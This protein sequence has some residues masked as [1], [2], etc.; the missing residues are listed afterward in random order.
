MQGL[1]ILGGVGTVGRLLG[2]GAHTLQHAGHF[3]HGPFCG[4]RQ[5]DAVVGV[6]VALIQAVDLGGQTVGDLQ[7]GRIVLGAVDTQTGC[8]A[9][10]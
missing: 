8:Q 2:Q 4:L 3:I 10:V 9:G 6:A 5:G 7:T 1:A